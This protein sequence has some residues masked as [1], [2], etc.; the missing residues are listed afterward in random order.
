MIEKNEK[1]DHYKP[2]GVEWLGEIPR[3]WEV[4]KIKRMFH[5]VKKRSNS[6]LNCGSISFGKVVFKD[7]E[8]IPEATKK[9][10]Q[11]VLKGDFLVNPLNLNYDLI[12]LR[13]ALSDI[14]VVVSSGYIVLHNS[15][16]IDKSYFKW[17]LHRFDVEHMKL[18]G[19]G[20]RQTLNYAD[21]GNCDLIFPP[22]AEQ[23]AIAAYLDHKTAQIDTAIAQKQRM[24]T[25]LKERQQILI[26]KA[27]TQ[28]LDP[29]V[30]R[31]KSGVEW[32]G[33]VPQHW[34]V[35]PLTKYAS[36]IDYRGK[37]PEKVEEGVFLVTT[38]NIKN[39]IIDYEISKEYVMEKQYHNI[40][41]R[42]LPIKGDILFTM[43]APLGMSAV[44]D[45]T[46]VAIAQRIIKFRFC[47]KKFNSSFVNYSIQSGYFQKHLQKEGTGS[48]AQGIKASKLHKLKLIS[49]PLN[50]QEQIVNHIELLTTKIAT[51]VRLKEAEILRLKE[52]KSSLINGVVTGKVRV[53]SGK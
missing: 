31:K 53:K 33:E 7:D 49:P 14:D 37:T 34:E 51:A 8:K 2:S 9:S 26:H 36:R 20:V 10:Y 41:S 15:I 46:D 40:M 47:Q 16:D 38:K 4:K 50:E 12:S 19:S 45:R 32:I 5:E 39:G 30:K 35:L 52:Y 3:H 29:S 42:G 21:I 25:L 6:E 17:L 44:V 18:L 43:E 23:T 24:I 11:V 1:Y 28:G 22:L 48:I 27:V 13:V